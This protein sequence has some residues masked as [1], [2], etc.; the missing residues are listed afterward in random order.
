MIRDFIVL[1]YSFYI[2]IEGTSLLKQ[3]LV[4][5][6]I[7]CSFRSSQDSYCDDDDFVFQIAPFALFS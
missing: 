7:K 2:L 5:C 1:L 3:N 6:L 4:T